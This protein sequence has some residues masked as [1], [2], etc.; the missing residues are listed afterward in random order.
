M[1]IRS[2][3]R[4]LME[5]TRERVYD[6][7]IVPKTEYHRL[8]SDSFRILMAY[9]LRVQDRYFVIWQMAGSQ[10]PDGET[11][12]QRQYPCLSLMT[13]LFDKQYDFF[14]DEFGDDEALYDL[15][16]VVRR[17]ANKIDEFLDGFLSED[18]PK[19]EM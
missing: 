7:E 6:W 3:L 19:S 4:Q 15:L 5:K 14:E 8:H 13:R 12:Y 17:Q 10:S 11:V 9:Q 18:D 16:D 2:V 1:K